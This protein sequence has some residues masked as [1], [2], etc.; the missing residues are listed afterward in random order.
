M[1]AETQLQQARSALAH[2]RRVTM[3]GEVAASLAHEIKQPIIAARIDAKV[4][5]G[6]LGEHRLDLQAARDAASRLVKDA[7]WATEVITRTTA[8]FKKETERERVNIGSVI[9]ELA[10]LLQQETNESSI[11]IQINLSP[12]TRDI[13]ADRIQLQQALMN[14]MLNA[15]DAMKDSGGDMTIT[16]EPSADGQLL[17]TV[18]D[19]GVGLPTDHSD[20]IFES[21]VTTKAGGTGMGLA[22]TR[23]IVESHGG[24]L[25]AAANAERGATFRFTIPN[26]TAE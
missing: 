26:D 3:M 8:L 23:S 15:I 11:S 9:H 1:R 7:A 10:V 14:L 6:A 19:T 25:W 16:A 20:D 18:S 17:V 5:L 4:C 22:I 13:M 12:D 24:R 2:R 21:F